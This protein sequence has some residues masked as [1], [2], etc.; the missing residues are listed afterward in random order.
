[1]MALILNGLDYSD[2]IMGF[3]DCGHQSGS[4]GFTDSV[5]LQ[6]RCHFFAFFTSLTAKER[7]GDM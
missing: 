7:G 4:E 5:F 1:M 6:L 3:W 2:N